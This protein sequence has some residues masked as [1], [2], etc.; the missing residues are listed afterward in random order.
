M[1][2]MYKAF[3]AEALRPDIGASSAWD[4]L[5]IILAELRTLPDRATAQQLRDAILQLHGYAGINGYYDFRVGN[6]RGLGL[7]DCIVVRRDARTK[8]FV[9]VSGSGGNPG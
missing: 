1:A 8:S 6:Q 2:S 4:P 7:K 3:S 5:S 9:A